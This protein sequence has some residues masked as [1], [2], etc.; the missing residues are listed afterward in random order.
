[1]NYTRTS[2]I[3]GPM[4]DVGDRLLM[5]DSLRGNV[6]LL[7]DEQIA[8]YEDSY[9]VIALVFDSEREDEKM[10]AGTIVGVSR[11]PDVIKVD[12]RL[13]TNLAYS[14][15]KRWNLRDV[16]CLSCHLSYMNDV[17]D[18]V[19]PFRILSPRLMD[20]DKQSKM[21]TLGVDLIKI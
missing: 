2:Y 15:Y 14:F 6:P 18:I 12:L 9:V 13:L 3:V 16:K 11:E 10:L 17:F 8:A 19:G 20:F 1:M 5:S 4:N 21:C 7:E